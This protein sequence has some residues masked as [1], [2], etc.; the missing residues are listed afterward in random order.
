MWAILLEK[1]CL[2]LDSWRF[3]RKDGAAPSLTKDVT[4]SPWSYWL[5]WQCHPVHSGF[6][7]NYTTTYHNSRN[8]RIFSIQRFSSV[9]DSGSMNSSQPRFSLINQLLLAPS[10]ATSDGMYTHARDMRNLTRHQNLW[11]NLDFGPGQ[12]SNSSPVHIESYIYTTLCQPHEYSYTRRSY[13]DVFKPYV[14]L[15]FHCK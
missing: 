14:P 3:A 11:Q 1:E 13:S 6:Q 5:Y 10:L 4:N 7:R 9:L 8:V 2:L 12:E 15:I